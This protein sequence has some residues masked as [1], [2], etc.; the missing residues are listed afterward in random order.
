MSFWRDQAFFKLLTLTKMHL[1]FA[2]DLLPC[3]PSNPF[4][5]LVK[6]NMHVYCTIK[7]CMYNTKN[8]VNVLQIKTSLL[9]IPL[10]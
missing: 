10:K 5:A 6:R 2:L 3:L 7:I 4:K 1:V 8:K 9:T